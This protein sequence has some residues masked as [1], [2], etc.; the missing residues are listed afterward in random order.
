M[1]LKSETFTAAF[2]HPKFGCSGIFRRKPHENEILMLKISRYHDKA[3]HCQVVKRV[4]D[5]GH[6]EKLYNQ[7]TKLI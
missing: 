2:V 7:V 6:F 4:N 1:Q 5:G 3:H